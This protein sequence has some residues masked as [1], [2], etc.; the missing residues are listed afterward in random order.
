MI[1]GLFVVANGWTLP[2]VRAIGIFIATVI[3]AR[4]IKSLLGKHFKRTSRSSK[5]DETPFIMVKRSASVTIPRSPYAIG[6]A[7]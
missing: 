5:I 3:I 4:I 1:D 6:T 2:V 7:P